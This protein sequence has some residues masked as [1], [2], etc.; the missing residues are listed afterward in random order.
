[1][2]SITDVVRQ[3]RAG[4]DGLG[5][6]C[7]ISLAGHGALLAVLVV[8]PS[9]FVTD[10]E[11]GLSA[12]V[13]NISPRGSG[14]A[15]HRGTGAARRAPGAGGAAPRGGEPPAVDSAPHPRPAGGGPARRGR[16]PP[17]RGGRAAGGGAGRVAG[18]DA[19]PGA[20]AARGQ[21]PRGHR[22]RGGRRGT[23]R[24]RARRRRRARAPE[25][26]LPGVHRGHDGADPQQL[27]PPSTRDR[28][29]DH[30]V[31]HSAGTGASRTWNGRPAAGTSPSTPAPSAPCS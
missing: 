6:T 2:Q 7:A 16:R 15:Q 11:T 5:R 28:R 23:L 26:L 18:P 24:R 25:L 14:R 27:E 21:R 30:Q 22:R 8:F 1:M 10:L 19:G 9:A 17:G 29:G 4:G 31:H 20:G 12:D 3:R 13:M